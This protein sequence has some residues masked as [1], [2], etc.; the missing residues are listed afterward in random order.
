MKIM[1]TIQGEGRG[2]MTQALAL[3]ELYEDAGHE[4]C[5]VIVGNMKKKGS[6]PAFFKS[7]FNCRVIETASPNLIYDKN[8]DGGVN[9][10][11]TI[12]FNTLNFWRFVR[13]FYHIASKIRKYKPDV[14]VNFYEPVFGFY[15]LLGGKCKKSYAIGH[16]FA[17]LHPDYVA[18]KSNERRLSYWGTKWFTKLIGIGSEKIA[19]SITEE[20]P[21]EGI[22][23]VPPILRKKLF[24]GSPITNEGFVLVYCLSSSY[25]RKMLHGAPR[26]LSVDTKFEVFTEKFWPGDDDV[27]HFEN[28]TFHK[29][30]GD[31]FLNYMR[32]CDMVVCTAGFETSS[33]AAYLGKKVMVI[34]TPKHVEQYFNAWDFQLAGLAKMRHD[35]DNIDRS[36]VTVNN[37]QID[38]FRLWVDTYKEQYKTVLNI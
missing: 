1:F 12:T 32:R 13:T 2:H 24:D 17:F 11:K 6:I 5:C 29:L 35:F 27:L 18:N 23:I 22:T 19:L 38:K 7:A 25:A 3:K 20:K 10:A 4:I 16:Q 37:K 9:I 33:E 14:I 30:D 21:G 31:K 28:V 26:F 34:P 8:S 36:E 15:R